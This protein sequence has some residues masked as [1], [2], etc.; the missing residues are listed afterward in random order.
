MDDK[1][2]PQNLNKAFSNDQE[3]LIFIASDSSTDSQ[4]LRELARSTNKDV[5]KAVV[6]NPNS[7]P[8]VLLGLGAEFPNELLENSVF[9]LLLL[10]NPNLVEEIPLPTLRSLLRQENVPLFI[11][12]QS[13]NKTDMEV[14]MALAN[15]IQTTKK[16]LSKLTQ[17]K[18]PQVVECASLHVNFA[19]ELTEEVREQRTKE[20]IKGII[21]SGYKTDTSSLNVLAQ[22]CPIP[23]YIFEHWVRDKS[24]K[25]SLCSELA[26]SLATPPKFLKLLAQHGGSYIRAKVANNHNTPVETL[27]DLSI[28]K[29]DILLTIYIERNPNTPVDVLER[30][31][32]GGYYSQT[33]RN[34]NIPSH[35]LEQLA[36]QDPLSVAEH[37]NTP[38]ELLLK[39]SKS[40]DEKLR[41]AVAG[42]PSTPPSILEKLA[43]DKFDDVRFRVAY[44]SNTPINILFQELARDAK[45][46][47]DI[48][49]QL[50]SRYGYDPREEFI[51][52]I[53]AEE[54]TSSLEVI[55]ERLLKD[56]GI[57]AHL[58]LA[59]RFDLPS[60]LLERLA[61]LYEN[62]IIQVE[63]KRN[64]IANTVLK[65]R[66]AIALN[67]NTPVRC[68]E[69]LAKSQKGRIRRAVA[70]NPNITISILELLAKDKEYT[71]RKAV[72]KR[73]QLSSQILEMLVKDKSESVRSNA[74]ANPN[75][76]E[77]M[78][79]RI[80][81]E[82]Y[83]GDFLKQNPNFLS[84][85]PNIL[86]VIINKHAKSRCRFVSFLALCQPE[87]YQE[88]LLEKSCSVS[89]LERFAVAQ[90]PKTT[91]DILQNLAKDSNQIVMAT[92]KEYLRVRRFA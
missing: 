31:K 55:L 14:Q 66:Q 41:K 29:G 75:L 20:V 73:T 85:H 8:D 67:P 58:F 47:V 71:V 13:V 86:T 49:S 72:A 62:N 44:N 21:P 79:E 5:R 89:W 30:A 87:I 64:S 34:R 77:K 9:S 25:Y 61:D 76:S 38:Q 51:L 59:K 4:L 65:V 19:G 17:S 80:L 70:G 39:F 40:H 22:V 42:N 15:N 36:E 6:E 32:E 57:H 16:V 18:H 26:D 52:N 35:A 24:Y 69:K 28:E 2:T 23:E 53:F 63:P 27:R 43:Y 78:S 11:L 46:N 50:V 84:S 37:P 92:A 3:Q 33:L 56:A 74:M 82:G 68:L 90:N 91:T 60:H 10:E 88:I 48:A 54:S 7:P 81:C 45:V 1:L 83:A 12:E